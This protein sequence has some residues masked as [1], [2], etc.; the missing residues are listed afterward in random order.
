MDTSITMNDVNGGEGMLHGFIENVPLD[1]HSIHTYA[2]FYAGDSI[3]FNML[4]G[5]PWQRGNRVSI[6]KDDNSMYLSFKD[7]LDSRR[8]K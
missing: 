4:L 6:D 5:R 8:S 3:P 7:P 1:L 2:N